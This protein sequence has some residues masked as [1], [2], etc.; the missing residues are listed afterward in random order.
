MLTLIAQGTVEALAALYDRYGR[1][2]FTV[3]LHGTGEQSGA[4]Q[5]TEHV[6]QTL[7]QQAIIV[8]RGGNVSDSIIEMTRHYAIDWRRSLASSGTP[9][10]S[11]QEP[12]LDL[13]VSGACSDDQRIPQRPDVRRTLEMLP[14]QQRQALEL[15]YYRGR[16]CVEIAATFGVPVDT[17][18][19]WLRLGLVQLRS[20]LTA[21]DEDHTGN[22]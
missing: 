21:E 20:T 9:R 11:T 5:V 7:S 17:V 22:M 15:A 12:S 19:G 8:R 16:T 4:E 18:R 1:V 14:I 3:A 6:F 10:S 13:N 2:V